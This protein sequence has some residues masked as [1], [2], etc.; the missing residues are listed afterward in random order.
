MVVGITT[1]VTAASRQPMA[2]PIRTTIDRVARPRWK[3]SSLAFSF[4]VSP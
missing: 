2:K 4:A 3:S 1:A